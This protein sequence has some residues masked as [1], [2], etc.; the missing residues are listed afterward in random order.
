MTFALI[1]LTGLFYLVPSI[2][3]SFC[4]LTE[5]NVN[6]KLNYIY[7]DIKYLRNFVYTTT[8]FSLLFSFYNFILLRYFFYFLFFYSNYLYFY[9]IKRWYQY[10]S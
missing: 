7:T 2:I 8:F 3:E 6:S 9:T 1:L 10:I 4:F 5:A